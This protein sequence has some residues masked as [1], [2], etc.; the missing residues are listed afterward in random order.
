M[1]RFFDPAR[2]A[3]LKGVF[4]CRSGGWV[5]N[6]GMRPNRL[7]PGPTARAGRLGRLVRATAALIAAAST[8]VVLPAHAGDKGDKGD[9][10]RALA[11]VQAGEVLPLA[12]LLE[13]LQRSHPGE[14]LELELEHE[15]GRWLY[16]V[17]LLEP[18]GRV[19]R[20]KLDAKTAEVLKLRRRGD[21]RADAERTPR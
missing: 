15:H 3:S 11:A 14:V 7:L 12:V 18:G 2:E 4:I 13:R 21:G 5:N 9:H 20:L 6:A 10:E 16:E 19:A 1:A 8:L 17:K